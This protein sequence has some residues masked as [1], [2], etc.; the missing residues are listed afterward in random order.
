MRALKS[1]A[2]RRWKRCGT[3]AVEVALTLPVFFIFVFGTFEYGRVQLVSNLL[4]T[5]CRTGAR[6]GAT[7]GVS[8]S[9][10]LAR[11]S[12]I[13]AA[14]IDT[15]ALSSVAKDA[16]VFDTPGPYPDN[17]SEFAA[18][19]DLELSVA[20]PRQLFLVRATVDY[21]DVAIIPMPALDGLTLTGQAFM[22]HE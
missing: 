12:Q 4:Q 5:A 17:P 7:E 1:R 13:L 10:A 11:V 20:E 6:Y 2:A 19:P 14:A 21:N 15:S 18:L 8:S 9:E 16:A 3:T 22:R